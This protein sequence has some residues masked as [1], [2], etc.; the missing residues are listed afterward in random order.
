MHAS[1]CHSR[2]KAPLTLLQLAVATVVLHCVRPMKPVGGI[3]ICTMIAKISSKSEGA[4][5]R[6]PSVTGT[7]EKL[8]YF[9]PSQGRVQRC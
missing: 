6:V 3:C 1:S 9:F 7:S 2:Y 4:F 5:F 8:C